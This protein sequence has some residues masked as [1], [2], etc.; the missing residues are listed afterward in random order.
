MTD[1]IKRRARYGPW[2]IW[3][4]LVACRL[5]RTI[6]GAKAMCRRGEVSTWCFCGGDIV[7]ANET[8]YETVSSDK[9][10]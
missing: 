2:A 10:Q 9:G 4:L 8:H 1:V 3:R 7:T 5:V 6:E